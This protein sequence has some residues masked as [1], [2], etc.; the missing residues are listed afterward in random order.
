MNSIDMVTKAED[1]ACAYREA[2]SD[3]IN[4]AYQMLHSEFIGCWMKSPNSLV[5]TPGFATNG[6]TVAEAIAD[7]FAGESGALDEIE[8]L[9]L[10]A[11]VARQTDANGERA[12]R[13]MGN[14]A[15]QHAEFHAADAI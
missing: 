13:L 15:A 5:Q 6:M 14:I 9:S 2:L 8:L 12:R 1:K 3:S 4:N 10:I 11:A 7:H